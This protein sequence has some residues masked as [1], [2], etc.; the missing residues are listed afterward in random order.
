[1]KLQTVTRPLRWDETASLCAAV[2]WSPVDRSAVETGLGDDLFTI[3]ALEGER[4]VGCGRVVD[5]G[6]INFYIQHVIVMPSHQGRG[7]GGRIM[8]A[9]MVW[10]DGHI[11]L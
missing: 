5:D 3:C 11:R 1:M 9:I 6:G 10:L 7:I 8:D 4:A 2:G